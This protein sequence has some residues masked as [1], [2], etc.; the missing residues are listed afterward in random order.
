MTTPRRIAS[1]ATAFALAAIVTLG[2]LGTVNGLATS[3][4][5]AALVAQVNGAAHG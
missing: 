1:R 5:P 3:P 2:M 4:A